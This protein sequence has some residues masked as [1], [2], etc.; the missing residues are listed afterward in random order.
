M[1]TANN[2]DP[3]DKYKDFLVEAAPDEPDEDEEE[4]PGCLKRLLWGIV[5]AGIAIAIRIWLD[6]L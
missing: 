4:E 3:K 6:E 5:T 2:E 1:S